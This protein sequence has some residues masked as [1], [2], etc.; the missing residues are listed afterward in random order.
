MSALE[1][2]P[3]YVLFGRLR[4]GRS[5]PLRILDNDDHHPARI[6]CQP[7]PIFEEVGPLLLLQVVAHPMLFARRPLEL[8]LDSRREARLRAYV[9]EASL[10]ITD[11]LTW[12]PYATYPNELA[13]PLTT[14]LL[15]CGVVNEKDI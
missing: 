3:D 2:Q 4:V 15:L 9:F 12:D 5:S 14:G 13:H 6:T 10:K 11:V 8:A 7:K 1:E